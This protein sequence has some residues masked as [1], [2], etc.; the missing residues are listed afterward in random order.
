MRQVYIG[1]VLPEAVTIPPQDDVNAKKLSID[2]CLM[3][4]KYL[5]DTEKKMSRNAAEG[6]V[7]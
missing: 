2:A 4:L 1:I 6:L 7:A 3:I 5:H